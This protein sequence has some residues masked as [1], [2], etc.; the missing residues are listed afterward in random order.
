MP[1][2]AEDQI[3][4]N[5]KTT[6]P[7]NLEWDDIEAAGTTAVGHHTLGPSVT[8]QVPVHFKNYDVTEIGTSLIISYDVT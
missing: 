8:V 7:T 1:H 4:T 5:A 6:A 2:M 3:M